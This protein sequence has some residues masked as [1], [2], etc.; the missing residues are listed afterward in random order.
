MVILYLPLKAQWYNMIECGIKKDEYRDMTNYWIR[1]IC[2]KDGV[3]YNTDG[4]VKTDIT[5]VC[6]SYGYTKRRMLWR[7]KDIIVDVGKAEWG[8]PEHKLFNIRL[9]KREP[10]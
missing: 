10:L 2:G 7:I 3:R 6:F 4:T 8:A 5:H 1:R 9:L